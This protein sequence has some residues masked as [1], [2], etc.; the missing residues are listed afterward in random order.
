MFQPEEGGG[1]AA[2]EDYVIYF[3]ASGGAATFIDP[4]LD[5]GEVGK[6][7][8][9]GTEF[10]FGLK[11][12]AEI[13]DGLLADVGFELRGELFRRVV[14][15]SGDTGEDGEEAENDDFPF[16]HVERAIVY[17][18]GGGGESYGRWSACVAGREA[19]YS[20]IGSS[21]LSCVCAHRN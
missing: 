14:E 3:D 6:M 5:G 10:H 11:M 2:A 8:A 7:D 15:G 9:E 1:A 20:K 4:Q 13:G 19:V 21:A 12:V 18:H 17:R 16:A